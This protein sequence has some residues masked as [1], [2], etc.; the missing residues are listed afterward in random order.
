MPR[1]LACLLLVLLTLAGG[2][3]LAEDDPPS[4]T[5]IVPWEVGGGSDATARIIA[6]LLTREL[7]RSVTVRN[8]TEG[9][10][11]AGHEA[12][13][14]AAPDGNTIGMVTTELNM[15]HWT[16][17][18]E[19]NYRDVTPLAL[20]N[21]DPAAIFVR[22]DSRIDDIRELRLAVI[23]KAGKL[24]ASG[25]R[26]GGIWHLALAGFLRALNIPTEAIEWRGMAGSAPAFQALMD[27]EID[28]VVASVPD[29]SALLNAGLV[30]AL[31]VMDETPN[32]GYP[33]I[34]TLKEALGIDWQAAAWRGIAAP[35]GLPRERIERLSYALAAVYQ[36]DEYID[37]MAQRGFGRAWAGPGAFDDFLADNNAALGEA[38]RSLGLAN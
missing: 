23:G 17:D 24:T 12:I 36:S 5:L 16:G 22:G 29:S 8:R 19:L 27:N 15:M 37:F 9:Q 10:G 21:R 35:P 34:P 31:V 28:F 14:K 30:R 26:R 11:V 7:G 32:P 18:T 3:V 13:A 25:T 1:L 33:D 6:S 38:L 4:L 20:M 2:G